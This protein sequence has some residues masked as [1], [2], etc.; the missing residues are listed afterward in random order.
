VLSFTQRNLYTVNPTWTRALG[1]RASLQTGYQYSDVTYE[2]GARLG[3]VDYRTHAGNVSLTY[4]L[5]ERDHVELAGYHVRFAAPAVSL[6]SDFYGGQA[7]AKHQ[8]T[9]RFHV[10]LSGGARHIM[11]TTSAA[12]GET[13]RD[14]DW[15]WL[16][17]AEALQRFERGSIGGTCLRTIN[18]S[19]FGLLIRTQ[20]CGVT[21]SLQATE[22]LTL[23]LAGQVYWVEPVSTRGGAP[24]FP[25]NRYFRV[26]PGLRWR[27]GDNW[28]LS[29]SYSYAQR[30]IDALGQQA[31]AN[32]TMLTLTYTLP[33]LSVAR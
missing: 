1:E 20:L 10:S 3:L 5:T 18:P 32:G 23:S 12:S 28:L 17:T 14:H 8:F 21:L 33:K 9:E 4:K 27:V 30:D 24:T 26:Q 19:G 16:Y 22:T 13:L 25:N 7:T 29:V 15:V 31:T 11:S 2:D 6:Q